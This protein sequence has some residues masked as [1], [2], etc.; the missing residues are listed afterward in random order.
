MV[1][2]EGGGEASDPVDA[3]ESG[4][5]SDRSI[6]ETGELLPA[7]QAPENKP[8]QPQLHPERAP[9]DDDILYHSV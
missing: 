5:N 2:R 3:S 1:E 9:K 4:V 7:E 6:G 8:V